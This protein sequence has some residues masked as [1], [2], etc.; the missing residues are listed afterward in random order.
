MLFIVDITINNTEQVARLRNLASES[1][2]FL[3]LGRIRI[4]AVAVRSLNFAIFTVDEEL[5]SLIPTNFS[6]VLFSILFSI[7]MLRC[8]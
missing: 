3:S 2:T 5:S 4:I 7:E 8:S 6:S 1:T